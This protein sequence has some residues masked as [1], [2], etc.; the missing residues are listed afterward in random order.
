MVRVASWLP[1]GLMAVIGWTGSAYAQQQPGA[2]Q[3]NGRPV[4]ENAKAGAVLARAPGRMVNRGIARY[5]EAHDATIA[6]GLL[7][8]TID[9]PP[10]GTSL[11]NQTIADMLDI[12]FRDLNL[13]IAA[14][15]AQQGLDGIFPPDTGTNGTTPTTPTADVSDI[16]GTISGSPA[17]E[18]TS[19]EP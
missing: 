14:L 1:A 12:V 4:W 17:T 18:S 9:E 15:I 3:L 13:L 6:H 7:R 5:N 19:A 16:L 8:V 10:P 11:V 2:E